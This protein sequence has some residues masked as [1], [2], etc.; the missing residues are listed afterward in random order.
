MISDYILTG[1]SLK[2]I[3]IPWHGNGELNMK[4]GGIK[5]MKE[6]K[7]EDRKQ[8][9]PAFAM[10]ESGPTKEAIKV[11]VPFILSRGTEHINDNLRK[12]Q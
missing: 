7:G 5:S 10:P 6:Y 11:A 9:A 8:T 3:R 4:T 2:A 1:D 12:E